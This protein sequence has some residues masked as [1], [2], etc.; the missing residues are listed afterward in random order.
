MTETIKQNNELRESQLL[1]GKAN[2]ISK[3]EF[4]ALTVLNG[5]LSNSNWSAYNDIDVEELT[6]KAVEISKILIKKVNL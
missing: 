4:M 1:S 3:S 2:E 5:L 6:N